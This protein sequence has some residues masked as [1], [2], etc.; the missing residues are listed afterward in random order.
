MASP[1]DLLVIVS[2]TGTFG[3]TA[4]TADPSSAIVGT[5]YTSGGPGH[6]ASVTFLADGTYVIAEDA[7]L[8]PTGQ[9]GV[10]FGSYTWNSASGALTT[11]VLVDTN[12][13]WGLSHPPSATA[14]VAGDTLTFLDDSLVFTRASGPLEIIGGWVG[15]NNFGRLVSLTVAAD[16]TYL[17]A[18]IDPF[19]PDSGMER[20][21]ATW[22]PVTGALH[23]TVVTNTNPGHVGTGPADFAYVISSVVEGDESDNTLDGGNDADAVLGG[24]GNDA[25]DGQAGD[26]FLDGGNG[27]DT[28]EGGTG[29]DTLE[30]GAGADSMTGGSGNDFYLV[31]NAGDSVVETTNAPSGAQPIQGIAGVTDTVLAT[32]D[33][34]LQALDL[35]ENLALAHAAIS[36]SGNALA[37]ELVGNAHSNLLVGMEGG[38]SILGGLGNDTLQGNQGSDTVRGGLGDDELRGG[39][40]CDFVYSGQGNDMVLGAFG[41]DELRGGMGNDTISAGQGNDTVF[42]G[43]GDDFL[44]TRLGNDVAT[45]GAGADKFWFNI[46]GAADAD[47]ILDFEAGVDKIQLDPG[48]FSDPNAVAYD[49][50]SGQLSYAGNLVVTLSDNPAFSV[51]D[52]LF[53]P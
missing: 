18:S 31:D 40:D 4:V 51:A 41:A 24:G 30:G 45:G 11:D 50:A 5:W 15:V 33:Y 22:D 16:G 1:G 36:G 19:G 35:V 46:A 9:P 32:I 44:Q 42:G 53:S 29:A 2:S 47:T 48:V 49:M 34:G 28:L 43:A 17:I 38:D 12:G 13:E 39:Q 23:P 52:L 27:T 21:S 3:L 7:P 14:Q 25:L 10:E 8:E 26:D 37:N 20:G 6:H